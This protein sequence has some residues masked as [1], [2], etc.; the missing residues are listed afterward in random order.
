MCTNLLWFNCIAP[1]QARRDF[2]KKAI[3]STFAR[4]KGNIL[5]H[6]NLEKMQKAMLPEGGMKFVP[7]DTENLH[8]NLRSNTSVV[9]YKTLGAVV[10][11]GG[12]DVE[13]G[14]EEDIKWGWEEHAVKEE[15]EEDEE[16]E[17]EEEEDD[18]EDDSDGGEGGTVSKH[19]KSKKVR[20]LFASAIQHLLSYCWRSKGTS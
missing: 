4:E 13:E 10:E 18:E 19:G 8:G 14:E 20:T 16:E 9:P 15:E 1:Y 7:Q 2:A 5:R 12:D 17:E 11:T 6:L 3:A